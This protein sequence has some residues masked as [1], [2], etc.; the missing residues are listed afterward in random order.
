MNLLVFVTSWRLFNYT[1]ASA[2][3]GF[4]FSFGIGMKFFPILIRKLQQIKAN[5]P[6]NKYLATQHES[7]NNTPSMGGI[8][9]FIS[10]ILSSVL[11]VDYTNSLSWITLLCMTGFLG[12]GLIDDIKK[13]KSKN[14]TF[15]LSPLNKLILQ[16]IVSIII[17]G[18]LYYIY[19]YNDNFK[20]V[21]TFPFLKN[22]SLNIGFLYFIFRIFIIVGASNAVNLTDGLDGLAIVPAIIGFVTLGC[23]AY[24]KGNVIYANHLLFNHDALLN[25]LVIVIS[26]LIGGCV[27]FLWY[28][29]HPAAIFMGDSGSLTIGAVFGLFGI[30]VK[31]EL[32]LALIGFIFVIECLSVMIQVF[33]FKKEKKRIFLMAPIHH[34]FEKS[35]MSEMQIVVRCWIVSII[36]CLI[37]IL[38]IKLR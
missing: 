25:E 15:G 3:L 12:I 31:E 35:G 11:F 24:I 36:A 20:N 26:C 29:I 34:H 27:A 2:M 32:L 1:T 38:S 6:I 14:N 18:V 23:F 28:N 10:Y 8:G 21:L 16:Y 13:I 37:A 5:Q 4:C 22:V 17:I 30:L 9:I 33:W 19:R 7:K